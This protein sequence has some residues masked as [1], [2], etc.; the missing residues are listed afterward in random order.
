M[1]TNWS[2]D[3]AYDSDLP[4]VINTIQAVL[5]A[6][7]RILSE[8]QPQVF[9]AGFSDSAIQLRIRA[10]A[11]SADFWTAEQ[12]LRL[13]LKNRFEAEGIEIPFPQRVVQ[14]RSDSGDERQ[15]KA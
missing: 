6:E 9:V 8:P 5:K 14:L 12:D 1:R 10:A 2:I 4:Q 11:K 3:V 13:A 7:S 15:S